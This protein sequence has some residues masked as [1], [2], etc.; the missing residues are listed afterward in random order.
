M[1]A[2]NF[3]MPYFQSIDIDFLIVPILDIDI[4]RFKRQSIFEKVRKDTREYS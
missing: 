3:L 4:K 1:F 2:N